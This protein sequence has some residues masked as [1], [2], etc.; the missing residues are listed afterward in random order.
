MLALLTVPLPA[1]AQTLLPPDP[2][3]TI[4]GVVSFTGFVD[5][6]GRA[7]DARE[8]GGEADTSPQPWIVSPIYTRCPRTCSPITA[9]LQRALRES[10]MTAADYRVVS[11]SF[12][13]EETGETLRKFRAAMQ[14]PDTWRT[15]RVNDAEALARVLDGLDF[16]TIKGDDGEYVH[17][18]L[19]AV[20][21]PDMRVSEYL[22]GI[23]F[24]PAQLAAAV[25]TARSGKRWL[26]LSG[27]QLFV[28]AGIGLLIS[29]FV[30][31]T[32][33]VGRRRR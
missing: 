23:T 30:F 1:A 24:S 22:F 27:G 6:Q 10:G 28:G 20:L 29:A 32:L 11:F 25:D 26:R 17:P 16:R 2:Q 19:V 15:L 14:V 33:M 18:N 9:G 13:P 7:F 8:G 21:T 5:E 31:F 4:G 3:R 12:D